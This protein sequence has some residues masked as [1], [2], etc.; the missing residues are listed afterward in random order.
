MLLRALPADTCFSYSRQET[1]EGL[2]RPINKDYYYIDFHATIDAIKYRVFH[3]EKKVKAMSKPSDEKKEYYCPRC[4]AQWTMYEVLGNFDHVSQSFLCQRCDGPLEQ[5]EPTEGDATGNEKQVRLAAQLD[6]VLKLLQEID[7][8]MIPKNDFD[9]AWELRVEVQR[10][11]NI[12]PVR[13]TVPIDAGR[14]VPAGVKGLNQNVIQDVR[15]DLT[16]DADKTAAEQAAEEKRAAE[17]AAQNLLPVWHTKSTVT[18]TAATTFNSNSNS[19]LNGGASL[20][21]DPND[22]D[23]KK[24]VP[25]GTPNDN[26]KELEAYFQSMQAEREKE[27]REDREAEES[28]GDEEDDDDDDEGDFEDVA[29]V[30]TPLSSQSNLNPA[31]DGNGAIKPPPAVAN[32][33]ASFGASESGSSAPAS[34]PGAGDE[35]GPPAKKMKQEDEG[36]NGRE[37]SQAVSDEDDEAE[38]EDAL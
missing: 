1:R 37:V 19:V 2:Q 8:A 4:K 17:I 22:E 29:G 15:V 9:A 25:L 36:A 31:N 32:N 3:L 30:G 20:K 6:R 24:N 16:T 34:T 14:G 23:D 26:D 10:D 5:Q 13:H 28:S 12:N 18:G 35:E 7:N 38:F 21:L 27:E 11:Q 33:G